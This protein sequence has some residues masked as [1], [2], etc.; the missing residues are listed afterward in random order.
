MKKLLQRTALAAAGLFVVG[1]QAGPF[2]LAGTD[3]DEHGSFASGAN[4]DGWLFMQRALEN[5]AAGVTNGNKTIY[6]LG[7]ESSALTAANSAF[8]GSS[9]ATLASGWSI[10][11]L[12]GAAAINTF[13]S[14]VGV[15]SAGI[16]MLDSGGNVGG[17]LSN[18]EEDA[19]FANR[20]AINSFVGGGGGLFSQA[21]DYRWLGGLVAGLSV[22]TDQE[23][24]LALT[25][26]GF[27]AF[28]GLN[29]GDLSAGP[30]HSNFLGV[31]SIPVLA[32][33]IGAVSRYNV[34]IGSSGG[35]ITDPVAAIPE[36]STY[37]LMLAG[38]G[39]VGF[40][41]RRRRDTAA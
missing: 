34:I 26:S 16:I 33:G 39:L 38:L 8:N 12:N 20:N 2:I 25:A 31:G 30:Y 13:F 32:T 23:T 29:N 41:A 1:A 9:L 24:G 3:A 27:A 5:I 6:T 36:P 37:A 17:G 14:G 4:Q 11:N 15:G 18:D 28:P 22:A 35:S 10:V 7:S 19:L 40:M 21:N